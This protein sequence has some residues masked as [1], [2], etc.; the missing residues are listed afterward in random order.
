MKYLTLIDFF[1]V[2]SDP[3]Y[4]VLIV[5]FYYLVILS[6]YFSVAEC[7]ILFNNGTSGSI[8]TPGYPLT[9]YPNNVDCHFEILA[10]A[11]KSVRIIR[12]H[13]YTICSDLLY[14]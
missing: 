9:M 13:A 4:L 10:P 6:I 7:G 1:S 2:F 8:M 14:V 5:S 11:G 12:E 3:L